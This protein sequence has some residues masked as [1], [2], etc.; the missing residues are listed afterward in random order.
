[1]AKRILAIGG[2][3]FV[4]RVFSITASR[5]SEIELHVVNRGN[6]PLNL[7]NVK[8]YKCDRHDALRLARVIPDVKFDAIVDF[9]AYNTGEIRAVCKA[10][11]GRFGQYVYFSTTSV[12]EPGDHGVKDE[13]SPVVSAL[14]GDAVSDY[15]AGKLRLE[16][17]LAETCAEAGVPYTVLRPTFIYG[18]FNYAPRESYFIEMI[19][20]RHDVPIPTDATARFS[21]VYVVDVAN[22]ALLCA[23]DSRAYNETFNLSAPERVTY[24]RLMSDF[25]RCNGGPFL[26]HE[27]TV[28]EVIDQNIP[29]PFPLTEDELCS[30]E[31]F[32]RSFDF[33]YTPFADG[34]EKTF[35]VFYS[36]YTS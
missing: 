5:N 9:C 26:S 21:F 12:Y 17:E 33:E 10:L 13:S 24:G 16:R 20:R 2:S 36:L 31:K 11:A 27:V 25:E 30:G 29:L 4:G 15:I 1:M 22:A 14:G 35:S 6:F 34:M 18:P 23:G 7:D 28:R 3:V 8:Q 19:A 32:A